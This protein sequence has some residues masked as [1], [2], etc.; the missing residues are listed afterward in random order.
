MMCLKVTL[1]GSLENVLSLCGG[2][3]RRSI[4]GIFAHVTLV[5]GTADIPHFLN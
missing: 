1:V 4:L 5:S 2:L 3:A